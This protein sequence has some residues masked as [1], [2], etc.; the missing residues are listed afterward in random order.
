MAGL[1]GRDFSV[2][3]GGSEEDD[4]RTKAISEDVEES[5][6]TMCPESTLMEMWR[7][8]LFNGVSIGELQWQHTATRWLPVLK[9]WHPQWY[10]ADED[11][12]VYVLTTRAGPVDV[13]FA[14]AD[15]KWVVLGRGDRPWMHGLVRALAVPWL[16]AQFAIRDW[17]RYS[18]RHGM[19]VVKAIVPAVAGEADKDAFFDDVKAMS[20]ETTVMLPQGLDERGGGFD[21]ELLEATDRSWEGFQGLIRHIHDTYAIALTGNNLTT[22]IEGGSYAAAREGGSVRNDYAQADGEELSTQLREQVVKPYVLF[23]HAD[24]AERIPWPKWN[25]SPPEDLKSEAETIKLAG[26]ALYALQTAGV[27]VADVAEF[28]ERFGVKLDGNNE[29]APMMKELHE[30]V[31][32]A[33]GDNPS[34]ARGFINGQLYTDAVAEDGVKRAR[35]SLAVD[36]EVVLRAIE[37]SNDY[38]ELRT[39]LRKSYPDLDPGPF[40]RLMERAIILTELAGRH[41]ALEDI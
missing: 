5:W 22:L 12:Q 39:K 40:M 25:T 35:K 30:V 34:D 16:V 36:L 1:F 24:G 27:R 7:W 8:R 11:R 21:L 32:L 17:A 14:G 19:P 13:P 4:E 2:D 31:K 3:C 26:E 18:E 28:G 9:V 38:D 20:T 15:G 10:Y 6:W 41:A 29:S 37:A 33:S 23:N